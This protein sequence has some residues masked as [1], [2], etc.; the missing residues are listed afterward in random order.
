MKEETA[1]S[2]EG[3]EQI[4]EAEAETEVTSEGK[5]VVEASKGAVQ[6]SRYL[7]MPHVRSTNSVRTISS[8]A[9]KT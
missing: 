4:G 8:L 5:K 1:D 9:L 7:T 2:E 6:R 3:E